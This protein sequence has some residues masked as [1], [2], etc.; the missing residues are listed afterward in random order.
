MPDRPD[1]ARPHDSLITAEEN[2]SMFDTIASD[3]DGTNKILS[4]GLDTF[5][6]TRAVGKLS[7]VSEGTYLDVGCGTGD[8][9][10]EIL[11]QA[12]GSR[13]LG[14]D[15]SEGMLAIGRTQD[16]RSGPF[17]GDLV[18]PGRRAEPQIRRQPL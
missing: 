4:F 2:R 15:P 16:P 17:T 9:A 8:I 6:R 5:W 13:V 10:L 1:N 3:Y 11:R 12:P 18:G 7:P 14:I